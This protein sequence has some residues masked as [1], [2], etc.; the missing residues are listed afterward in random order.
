MRQLTQ[1]FYRLVG[2]AVTLLGAW[3]L[4]INLVDISYSGWILVWILS[5]GLL[6]AIGGVLFLLSFDGPPTARTRQVRLLG[7]LCMLFLA[8]LPWSFQFVMLPLVLLTLPA[9]A[10]GTSQG[11]AQ[12]N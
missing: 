1:A 4:F 6:G 2:L 5:A 3:V 9:L 8:L 10:T 12:I 11:A 7:W